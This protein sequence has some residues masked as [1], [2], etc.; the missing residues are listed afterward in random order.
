ME[1]NEY[2]KRPLIEG[3]SFEISNNRIKISSPNTIFVE[4]DRKEKV[5]LS[6]VE[7]AFRELKTIAKI[8]GK[9]KLK[10]VTKFLPAVKALYPL[11]CK[12]IETIDTAFSE[13]TELCRKLQY[14]GIHVGCSDDELLNE[15]YAKQR[16]I[17]S[18][19]SR[20]SD[21]SCFLGYYKK[22]KDQLQNQPW[23]NNRMINY[24]IILV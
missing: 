13:L 4:V 5:L 15:V 18:F 6:D 19:F 24:T 11:Y 8:T 1:R 12:A 17:V 23:K 7:K 2:L 10:G 14:D 9:V 21:Y 16:E 20:D 3:V 22:I